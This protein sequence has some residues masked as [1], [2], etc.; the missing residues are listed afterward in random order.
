M[1]LVQEG[2]CSCHRPF[3]SLLYVGDHL[4]KGEAL[5]ITDQ[6]SVC[7]SDTESSKL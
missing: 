5:M 3:H 6:P 2:F 7:L 4:L 1:C